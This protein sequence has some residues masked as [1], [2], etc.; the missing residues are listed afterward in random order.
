MTEPMEEKMTDQERQIKEAFIDGYTSA[1]DL[2]CGYRE[3]ERTVLAER[4]WREENVN[5]DA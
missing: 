2:A 3:R 1:L 5:N 4:A